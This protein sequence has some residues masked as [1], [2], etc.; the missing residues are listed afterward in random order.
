M[1][2]R[3]IGRKGVKDNV[4]PK[5]QIGEFCFQEIKFLAR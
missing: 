2:D 4:P 5:V 1:A 3:R